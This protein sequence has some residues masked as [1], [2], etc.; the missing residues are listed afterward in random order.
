MVPHPPEPDI[1]AGLQSLAGRQLAGFPEYRAAMLTAIPA[2]PA[3][4]SWRARSDQ[5]LGVM[6]L[7]AWSVVLDTTGFY[8]ARIA[9]R[10]Y[11]STAPDD[12]TARRLTALIGHRPRPA[13]AASVKLAVDADGADPVTLPK[14]TGFRSGAF[15]GEAPQVFELTAEHKIWP[16]RNRLT[17][18]PVRKAAFDGTLRFLSNPAPAAGA[19]L[20]LWTETRGSGQKSL[21][22]ALRVGSVEADPAPD[23]VT[24]QKVVPETESS[25]GL[26]ALAASKTPR[27][28]IWVA[29]MRIPAAEFGLPDASASLARMK[30]VS[31]TGTAS[32]DKAA[33]SNTVELDGIYPQVRK[34]QR[35]VAEIGAA[36]HPVEV[37]GVE[38]VAKVIDSSTTPAISQPV[39]KVTFTPSLS[40]SSEDNFVLH[41]HP[42]SLASPS[43]IAETQVGLSN[44][45]TSG[46]LVAPVDL[47]NAP[48]GGATILRGTSETGAEVSGSIVETGDGQARFAADPGTKS[49]ATLGTPVHLH[50][51]VVEAVRG[52]T[53][54]DEAL[55]SGDAGR[56]N[57]SFTLKKKPL[58]WVTDAT[59]VSGRRPD[60]TVRVNGITWT[61]VDTFFGRKPG[62]QVY[63]VGLE[64]D[65]GSRIT[66]GDGIRGARLPSGVDNVRATYRF[67]AGA[68]K[69][70][71][72]SIKSVARP[73]PGLL[74]VIGPLPATGGSDAETP[75]ELRRSAS[76]SAL[77]LGRAVSLQDFEAMARNYPGILN[78]AS[79]WAWDT[80]RQRA[81]AKLW[82]IPDA[83]DPSADLRAYLAER[84][85]PDLSIA[86]DLAGKAEVRKLSV[87]LAFAAGYD[88][89]TVKT[90]ISD[91]LFDDWKGFLSPRNQVIGGALFR[92]ALT[93]AI[94]AVPGVASVPTI[95]FGGSAMP[96]GVAA[97][98][99]NWFDLQSGTT[100]S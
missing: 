22:A 67:G 17:L 51:N 29:A 39:T 88:P 26:S 45:T 96:H 13:M 37:T 56:R 27:S 6:L 21:S 97:G 35:A 84:A 60:L 72:G 70:P 80:R 64:D 2:E 79:A 3:L 40:W 9:E 94:H 20:A 83:G 52:E 62:D 5:D 71:A 98:Q 18:A 93:H 10:S 85:A 78:A 74:D 75:D 77:T 76:A 4:A 15:D 19:V 44:V 69:P 58:A 65:G 50:G 100:V 55:G 48:A 87:T 99:G 91:A 41:I 95:L 66:F 81:A 90:A 38:R 43:R 36:L 8:D 53:V 31:G 73:T 32:K 14:G 28:M 1:S 89:A 7:E 59:L 92:S 16:E 42:F 86:V 12:A 63:T 24:Y 46:A 68:A 49:F 47:G 25:P 34:G 57:Q 54:G 23:G 61:R 33:A 11:L 30:R 82:I